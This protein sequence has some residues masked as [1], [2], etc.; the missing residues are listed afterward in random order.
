MKLLAFILPYLVHIIGGTK[1]YNY[2]ALLRAFFNA[3]LTGFINI[4]CNAV[5]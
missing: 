3:M 5:A 2:E 4:R 1:W